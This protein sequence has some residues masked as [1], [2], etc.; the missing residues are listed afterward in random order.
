MQR[1]LARRA[2]AAVRSGLGA[3]GA[4]EGRGRVT[5]LVIPDG[6][7]RP[8]PRARFLGFIKHLKILT[9]EFGIIPLNMLGT[10]VYVLDEIC[11]GLEAGVT[12]FVILKAR[13]L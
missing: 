1:H 2:D 10:Q 12:S 7:V 5:R 9:K 6:R 8:F 4:K 3:R 13:Q 11:K